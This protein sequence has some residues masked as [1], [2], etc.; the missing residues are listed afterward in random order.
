MRYKDILQKYRDLEQESTYL[1]QC[2]QQLETKVQDLHALNEEIEEKK[3]AA[4]KEAVRADIKLQH[5][6]RDLELRDIQISNLKSVCLKNEQDFDRLLQD[7]S[8]YEDSTTGVITKMRKIESEKTRLIDDNVKLLNE[9]E[10]L[11]QQLLNVTFM[12]ATSDDEFDS[13]PHQ[14]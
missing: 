9:N 5:L 6:L 4:K 8:Q 14:K 10:K 3:V 2:V 7:M 12:K 1:K 13:K 11:R